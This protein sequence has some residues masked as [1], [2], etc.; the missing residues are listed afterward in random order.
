MKNPSK[1]NLPAKLA[2]GR[3]CFEQWRSVHKPYSRLPEHLWAL[4][5]ELAREYG[6]N[7]V[8]RILR[9]DYNCLKK[10]IE[11]PT[12]NNASETMPMGQFLELLPS[13]SRSSIECTVECENIKGAK[14]RIHLKGRELPDLAA[15]SSGLWS[16][17][18]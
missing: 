1:S 8:A 14:I 4:A 18:R 10:R 3:R 11:L 13:E 16:Q 7:K 2:R 5:A 9:L 6:L 17:V 15:L 12:S